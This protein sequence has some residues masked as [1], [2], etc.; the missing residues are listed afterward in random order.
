MT[1]TNEREQA[2][3]AYLGRRLESRLADRGGARHA[4]G[5]EPKQN[6]VVGVLGAR[7]VEVEPDKEGDAGNSPGDAVAAAGAEA[8]SSEAEVAPSMGLTFSVTADSDKDIELS[9]DVDCA[10]YLQE[11]PSREEQDKYMRPE[12]LGENEHAAEGGAADDAE[13]GE[14]RSRKK[15]KRSVGLVPVWRRYNISAKGVLLSVPLTGE[16]SVE[17]TALEQAVREAIDGH[18]SLPVAARPFSTRTRTVPSDSI[19]SEEK[20]RAAI[21]AVEDKSYKALYP[22]LSLTGFADVASEN[23]LV[24]VSLSNE[25]VVPAK[26]FQDVAVYDCRLQVRVSSGAT[27]TPQRFVLAPHDYR[28]EDLALVAGHGRGCVAVAEAEGIAT[29]TLPVHTQNVVL[30]RSDHV[31]PLDWSDLSKDPFPILDGVETAMRRYVEEW[32]SFLSRASNNVRAASTEEKTRFEDEIRR[33]RLGQSVMRTDPRL[34]K[35]FIL[36]NAVFA[37]ANESRPYSA[38]RLFQLVF[39]V[40]HLPA[41]AARENRDNIDLLREIEH[42]DVLWFPTGGGKT[43]AYLGLIVA[44]LFYDRLR[45]KKRGVSA[46]LKFPLRMLSVQQL[47]RVL[48]VLVIAEALRESELD[49]LQAAPFRLGYLVGSSNTPNSLLWENGWWPGIEKAAAM[50]PELLDEYKLIAECP[51]CAERA[52]TLKVDRPAVRLLHVCTSCGRELPVIMS[53]EEI[54]RYLPSVLVGTIDKLSGFAFFGEYSQFI[55]GPKYTCPDHGSFTFPR[56]GKCL[57]QKLCDRPP[58]DWTTVTDYYDPVPAL[59]LQD[60]L[61]LVREELGAF[62]AHY[63]GLLAELQRAGPSKLPSKMLAASATIEQ[64]EDQLRQ[65][66]GRKPRSFPAPGFDRKRSFYT[67]ETDEVRRVFV[68]VL[69]HYRRKADVGGIVQQELIEAVAELQDL[70][71][72]DAIE[73]LGLEEISRTELQELFFNY[74]VSLAY[75]N[76]KSHGDLIEDELARLSRLLE[77]RGR[78]RITIRKLTG[79]VRVT[80]LAEAIER[81]EDAVLTDPRLDRLRALVGTSVVSH[82]VDLERLNTMVMAGLPTTVADYIQATSRSGRAHVGLV[83]TVFDTYQRRERSSFINFMSFHRFLDRLVEP[84]PV[85]K[86]ARFGADRTLPGIVMALLWD[87]CR[88]PNLEAP[89]EGVHFTRSLQKWWNAMAPKLKPTLE[90]RIARCYRAPVEGSNEATLE[91]ELADRAVRRWQDVEMLKM[92]EFNTDRS[93]DLFRE[94][95]LS[96]FRDIDTPVEF[97]ALPR[98]AAAFEALM[99]IGVDSAQG[100][101]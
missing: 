61:H 49:D 45:G 77:D 101:D 32:E 94:R 53:D 6:V 11:Y 95:V 97:A 74:E 82:G 16:H 23:Y 63:E 99:R 80:E 85:N 67:V 20:F 8:L 65:V 2:V 42:A 90:A 81:I 1:T 10:L 12:G 100:G 71:P 93:R 36:A 86:F 92:Q 29:H 13:G 19:E 17:K 69:P 73:R 33:F 72:Q 52:V 51:Y 91:D 46:W 24:S 79:E 39:I 38:W 84:V 75:V 96:S 50:D 78:D 66:Y 48:R 54:Y 7:F 89:E 27:M 9:I 98:S 28:F 87:L 31:P 47:A 59:V 22:Q 41:L 70:E 88:D 56:G 3:V 26:P 25:T 64:Y 21:R 62:D 83:V 44:A 68:G 57:A 35:A 15:R 40:S 55:H 76:N 60:E 4:P 30:P 14:E 34:L 5:W 37:K 18:F 58:T 43:E